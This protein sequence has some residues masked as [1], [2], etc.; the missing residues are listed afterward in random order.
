[1]QHPNEEIELHMANCIDYLAAV[2]NAQNTADYGQLHAKM[3]NAL[4]ARMDLIYDKIE[5]SPE[6]DQ[7]AAEAVTML[8]EQPLSGRIYTRH[9]PM[10][11]KENSNGITIQGEDF[12]GKP[13]SI[14]FLSNNAVQKIKDLT[15]Q[16]WEKPRCHHD[17]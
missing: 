7:L 13:A 4:N 1:M 15:G 14:V 2:V 17:D 11:Y 9:L 10:D 6:S 5:T 16:G 12:Q 3:L 8:V